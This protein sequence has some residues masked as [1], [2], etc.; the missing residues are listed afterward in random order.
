MAC[1]VDDGRS[2]AEHGARVYRPAPDSGAHPAEL[3]STAR[4]APARCDGRARVRASAGVC[5]RGRCGGTPRADTRRRPRCS[6]PRSTHPATCASNDVPEPDR[7]CRATWSSSV[8]ACGI[9]GSDVGYVKLGGVAGPVSEPMPL[10]HELSG[11][12]SEI[13]ERRLRASRSERAS[14]STPV[15][16]GFAIG[17]GGPDGGFARKL[18]V[19]G[20][21][22]RPE[23]V[24][25]PGRHAGRRRSTRRAA[26]CRDERRRSRARGAVATASSCSAPAR[27][28]L[29]PSRRSSTAGSTT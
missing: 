5:W 9:C 27:S 6:E 10:G 23:P 16:P 15:R 29:P 20:A 28:G 11:V 2:R 3:R 8:D 21:A 1:G 22:G 4:S 17:N 19:R 25:D 13:G 24:R 26:R 18:L 12:V 7:R 14:S